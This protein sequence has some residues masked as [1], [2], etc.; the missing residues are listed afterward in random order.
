MTQLYRRGASYVHIFQALP[1]IVVPQ[2]QLLI[3]SVNKTGTLKLQPQG[4]KLKG[5]RPPFSDL[6][7]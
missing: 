4:K 2:K 7:I 1:Y 5:H 6:L 3:H